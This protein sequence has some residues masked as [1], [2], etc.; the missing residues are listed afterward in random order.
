MWMSKIKKY[1]KEI[2][3]TSVL[4]A[5]FVFSMICIALVFI[6]AVINGVKQILGLESAE[7]IISAISS[8]AT[9]LTLAFLVYQYKM[10]E[11]KNYQLTMVDEAKLVLEKIIEQLDKLHE[12]DGKNILVL[13]NLLNEMSNH[14]I[15]FDSFYE[16]VHDPALKKILQIRWQDMFLNHYLGISGNIDVC[17]IIREST[18]NKDHVFELNMINL[19]EGAD[20]ASQGKVYEGY[21]HELY[22]LNKAKDNGLYDV[23]SYVQSHSIF[24]QYFFDN[25]K[26]IKYLEGIILENDPRKTDPTLYAIVEASINR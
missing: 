19:K 23:I 26:I 16:E 9:A 8:L 24:K 2:D 1:L 15:D 4:N 20:E 10:K 7:K 18:I 17:S 11:V 13:D 14:A 12:W 21:E 22:C 25:T 5:M 6:F 3:R